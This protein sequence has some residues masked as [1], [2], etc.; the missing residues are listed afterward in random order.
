[1]KLI[2]KKCF[3]KAIQVTD[4]FHV[5]KLAI[6]ALQDIRIKHRWEA[7]DL[8]NDLIKQAK[9][10]KSEFK[11][12]TFDNGD[13]RKQLLARSRYLLYK[14]PNNWT[15]N[16]YLR[17]KILF[18]QYPDIKKAYNL[19]QGLRNIFNTATSIQTAYTK[20]AHWYKDVEQTGFKAFN[21]IA[22]TITINYKSIL[23]YFM[24]RSTN[25]SAESF[26]ARIK[27]F[28]A[29]FRG[30]KNVEFFLFRLTNIFA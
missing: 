5:Q 15:Q 13:T 11:P 8:E 1:M 23:N 7:I 27:A 2:A 10:S 21:T 28:R 9:A 24:N 22:N 29:Q 17:S 18:D 19:V 20:L 6:E 30:V 16:Q 25:A 4:R 26:N 14:A 3:P 12:E